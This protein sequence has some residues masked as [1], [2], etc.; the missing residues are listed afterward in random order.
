MGDHT[1]WPR[2][3]SRSLDSNLLRNPGESVSMHTGTPFFL[4]VL[5]N[6]ARATR[7]ARFWRPSHA[8]LLL[9]HALG[10]HRNAACTDSEHLMA[11]ARWLARAQDVM[12]D[13]G[14][15]GRFSL[16]VGWTS[17]Y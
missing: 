15:A 16:E 7:H 14:V 10:R 4:P 2:A 12:R 17:S 5:M 9:S 13:G 11:A 6:L 3:T 1:Y 8:R